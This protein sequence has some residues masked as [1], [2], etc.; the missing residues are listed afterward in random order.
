MRLKNRT[1]PLLIQ[2]VPV[3]DMTADQFYELCQ[4]NQELRI[5]RTAKGDLSI[6][7]PAGAETGSRN[8]DIVA[9][10]M[11]WA[12]Q[13]RTGT[14]FDSSAG[15]TL[16]NGAVRSPDASWIRNVKLAALT[17]EEK[18]A[19]VSISPDLAIELRSPSDSIDDLKDKMHEY[20]ENGVQLGWLIDRKNKRVYVYRPGEPVET[21]NHPTE[22]AG[23]PELPGFVL[24]LQ[25][26]WEPAF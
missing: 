19:F 1:S 20:M 26:I 4:L 7:A 24:N 11:F 6:I 23:D 12:R 9:D 17:P 25:R 13:D 14:V 18:K 22:I 3:V 2:M 10:L 5:E 16:P 15:F 8:A 21:L